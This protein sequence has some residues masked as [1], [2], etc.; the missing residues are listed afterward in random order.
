M[1]SKTHGRPDNEQEFLDDILGRGKG[2]PDMHNYPGEK[3]RKVIED[4]STR[5]TNYPR[6]EDIDYSPDQDEDW[7]EHDQ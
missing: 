1:M 6:D 7:S 5:R 4:N 3:I 2:D